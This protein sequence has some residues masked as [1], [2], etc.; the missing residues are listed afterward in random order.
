MLGQL[1]VNDWGNKYFADSYRERTR[2]WPRG[3]PAGGGGGDL[4]GAGRGCG[5]GTDRAVA[6]AADACKAEQTCIVRVP[7]PA[8]M[9]SGA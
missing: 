7:D 9:Q 8:R 3:H 1:H 5:G 6:T 4:A 2:R